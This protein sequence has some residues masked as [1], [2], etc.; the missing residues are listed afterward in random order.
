M[1]TIRNMRI[2]WASSLLALATGTAL[3]AA[4]AEEAGKLGT[5]LT[6]TGAE[7]AG[8]ADGSIPEYSGG[9]TTPP[10]AYQ[11]GSGIRPDPYAGEKPLFSITAGNIAG[12]E[13]KLTAGTRELLV[14]NPDSF[15]V[16]VYP[17][18][19][20]VAFPQYVLDN[21][22]KNAT[23]VRTTDEG[24]GLEG[25]HAGI[26]FPIPKTGNEV[27]WNHLLR[28]NGQSYVT[29]YDSINVNSAGKAVLAT[30]GLIHVDYPYY[31]PKR[32]GV[33]DAGDV[34]FRTK[35]AYTAPARRAGEALL[36]QDYINPMKNGRKAWQYLPG[37]RR[38]K[39]APDI[40]YD[41]PNPGS[42]G[43]STYDDAWVFNG[44]MDRYDFKLVGKREMYIPY[45]AFKL[46]FAEDPFAV[47]TAGHVNPD[48]LRWELHR[49]WVVE[50]TLKPGKRHVYARRVFYVDE[51][52]WIA[53][54]SDQYDARGQLFRAGFIYSNPSYDVPTP[55]ATGQSFH[56]FVRGGYNITGL[57]GAYRTGVKFT[58]PLSP[59]AWAPEALAGAGIR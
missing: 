24:L 15:R 49:V 4:T 16:D 56:D 50:A 43:A 34:Y 18:H 14:R 9:L 6:L 21:T 13:D 22:R 31:D 48:Y 55:S 38:V 19:R 47:A 58:S 28:Y 11:A 57:V 2:A 17:T 26:P 25:T 53:V 7:R 1:I 29:Q 20:S 39:L 32:T 35:I 36:A 12:Y 40:A 30:T 54:A 51:D 46:V 59:N 44:A 52:S 45:N 42:A 41:T 10:A 5:S 33:S 3:A 37:Q 23:S 8:N 27:M